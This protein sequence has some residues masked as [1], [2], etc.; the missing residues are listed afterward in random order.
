MRTSISTPNRVSEGAV[1]S[2]RIA[3]VLALVVSGFLTG[4]WFV[5]EDRFS[6]RSTE[7]ALTAKRLVV[8][9]FANLGPAEDVYFA[10]GISEELT[11]RLAAVD[12]LRVI[13]NTS[14]NL[15]QGTTKTV[16]EIGRDLGVD[17]VLEGT[18]RWQKLPGGRARV[19]VTTQLVSTKDGIHLW[20]EIY[21]E[22]LDEIFRV[23]SDIAKKVVQ[24]LDITLLEQQRRMF[25]A[26]P[27][28]SLEAYDYY[29]RGNDYQRQD[30]GQTATRASVL[31]YER[32]VEVDSS[33]A[34]AYARLARAHTQMYRRYF[35][36]S[37]ER[38]A[39]AKRAVDKA[40]ELQPGLLEAHHA[41]GAYHM[42]RMGW[43]GALRELAI[44]E[45]SRPNDGNVYLARAVALLRQ[46]KPKES[47]GEFQKA[48]KL[49][50]AS[51]V[52][53]SNH[54]IACDFLRDYPRAEALYDRSIFLAPDRFEPYLLKVWLYVRWDG[55]TQRAR[56]VL[57]E[58][59]NAG[60][61]DG[62]GMLY[63]RVLLEFFDRRTEAALGL[64]AS[65]APEVVLSDQLRVVPRAQLYA[66]IY[67]LMRRHDL[68][69]AYYDS[70]RAL[71]SGKLEQTPEDPRLRTA[72]GI[73]YAGL[74][75]KDEAV[76]EAEKA[77][78]LIPISKDLVKGYHHAWEAARIYA[79]VGAYDG[80]IDQLERLLSIPGQLTAAQVS[81]DPIWD[82][83]RAHPRFQRLVNRRT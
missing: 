55:T 50:P 77:V 2:R 69:R 8:I 11:A 67:G 51:S 47:L 30:V 61:V 9:P 59:R 16:P 45:V 79:M 60:V 33:F 34:L 31:M 53:A 76:Q 83:L 25:E 24:A 22:R 58:A 80:A 15:Y 46:G 39:K 14:A 78:E 40:F 54:G 66:Q 21:D 68:E 5:L 52:V 41:L 71:I 72:L 75:R 57:A 37:A 7:A 13:G 12:R 26:A 56:V 62:P 4:G 28:A 64:L 3:A 27:T 42:T 20:A 49:D 19:R 44:E 81:F 43:D 23:Q 6:V 18:V 17:Y 32:A 48:Q 74:G 1:G 29:L 38:L 35:D 36:F 10:A 65:D 63:A 82:P 73:A 70:A